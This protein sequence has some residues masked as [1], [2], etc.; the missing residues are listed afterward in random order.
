MEGGALFN[1]GF[2]GGNFLWWVGQIADDSTWRENISAG[3]IKSKN[4]TPGWGYRYKVRIIGLHDQGE[5]SIKSQQLPWAQVMYPITAGGGQGG[6][7]QTPALKQGNFVFGFFLDSQDQQVPVIMGVLGNNAS[8]KLKTKTS[9][10]PSA[11]TPSASTPGSSTATSSVATSA[12]ASVQSATPEPKRSDFPMGRSGANTFIKARKKWKKEQETKTTANGQNFTPQSH[13]SKGVDRDTTKKVADTELA[14]EEPSSG[15]LPTKEASD[16]VHQ[17]T[18][19]DNKKEKI[20]KRKHALACPDPEQ[21]SEMTAI[22]TVIENMTEKI[23]DAQKALQQYTSAVSLPIKNAFKDINEILSEAAGEISKH[24]KK[25]FGKVQNFVTEQINDIAQPLLKIS[26]PSIRIQLL[27]DLVKGFEGLVCAFN[28][29]VGELLGTIL[30][31]LQNI[32]NRKSNSSRSVGPSSA[33]SPQNSTEPQVGTVS[34]FDPAYSV[35]PLPPEGYYTPNPICSTEELVGE[36]LGSTLGTIMASVETA[37]GPMITRVSATS[38]AGKQA[39]G[40]SPSK[41]TSNS[42]I[43][44]PAVAAA[45]ASG[46]LVAGLSNALAQQLD[47]SPILIGGVTSA[48]QTGDLVSGLTALGGLAGVDP[49]IVATAAD[50][51]QGGDVVTGITSLFGP[52]VASFGQAFSAIESGDLNSLVGIIGPLAGA[53]PAIL[54]A[55]TGGGAIAG[56]AGGLGAL[57]G[58]NLDIAASLGFISSITQFFDCDPKPMCSPN[59][60]YTLQEGGSGKP[61]VEK[62]NPNQVADNAAAQ[63]EKPASIP[64]TDVIGDELDKPITDAERQAVREGRI[65]DEQ[66]NTIGTI[67]SRGST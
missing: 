6:S 44:I 46:G 55:I 40:S 23:Q 62:P 38:A 36:V 61:G 41:S 64:E 19:E 43:S 24:M 60:T 12:A 22:Q 32:M 29:I 4:D 42:G 10:A 1:P 25:I 37:I 56:L 49:E 18:A 66:G 28:G 14:S 48:L 7:F 11:S 51:L 65:I 30:G 13:H 59:D 58:I 21:S 50:I 26:P 34:E 15:T 9:L 63:A 2:L 31:A 57:G 52:D 35:P 54:G 8:T 3:K 39:A 33:Q 45:L 20:L 16:S 67:T 53:N 27:D 5:A 47:V 17:E